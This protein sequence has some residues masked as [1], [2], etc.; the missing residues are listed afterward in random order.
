MGR[1]VIDSFKKLDPR[2]QAR[3]PVMFVVEVG[4]AVVSGFFLRDLL[5]RGGHDAGFDLAIGLWLWFTVLFANFAEAVAE[6]RGKAQAEYLRRSKTNTMARRVADDGRLLAVNATELR[7]GDLI[8]VEPNETIAGD[9]EVIEGAASVDE[10]AITGESAPVIRES[11]ATAAPSRAARASSPTTSS[12]AS[13]R[14]P[15]RAFSTA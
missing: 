3:N 1:A 12:C 7:K 14:T 2:W 9:G 6:G 4:A 8:R 11:A 15:A 10:S 5:A 13:P